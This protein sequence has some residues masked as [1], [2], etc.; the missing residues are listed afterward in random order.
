MESQANLESQEPF[1]TLIIGDGE[2]NVRAKCPEIGISTT[3]SNKRVAKYLI[4]SMTESRA[5]AILLNK[6]EGTLTEDITK[7]NIAIAQKIVEAKK[8]GKKVQ[9]LFK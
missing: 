2:T 4:A 5:E 8:R 3:A 1:L 7:E 9:D 6:E